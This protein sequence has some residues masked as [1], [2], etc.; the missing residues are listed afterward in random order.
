MTINLQSLEKLYPPEEL[1][2]VAD[3]WRY[4][5]SL[6]NHRHVFFG[7]GYPDA[8]T[9]AKAL[10][11]HCLHLPH[12]LWEESFN[13]R[14]THHERAEWWRLLCVR[15]HDRTPMAYLTQEAYLGDFS[16]YVDERVLIPRSFIAEV[17][18]NDL[19]QPWVS[20]DWHNAS[21][22]ADICTGGGSLA[23]LLALQCPEADVVATD[24]S[25]EALAVAE[26]NREDYNLIHRLELRQGHLGETLEANSYDLCLSNPPYVDE[27]AMDKLP[28]E[29]QQ[30]P[31][32]ALE[33]GIQGLDHIN[34]LLQDAKRFLAP[35][36]WL[37]LEVGHQK[38]KL[39]RHYP[40]TPFIWLPLTEGDDFVLA[41]QKENLP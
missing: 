36:G 1:L 21:R 17:L 41:I 6:M 40:N 12:H 37:V 9:E 5:V 39:E 2:T 27:L 25:F 11:L 18:L 31:K 24:I 13:T 28:P 33:S 16:F 29:Y 34:E 15:V 10:M 26:I 32:L 35:E 7:H 19:L 8:Q 23:V 20:P 22:V 30:E 4:S 38:E 14:I 3:L